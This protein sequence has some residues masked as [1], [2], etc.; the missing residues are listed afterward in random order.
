MEPRQARIPKGPDPPMSKDPQ[1]HP[2]V[3]PYPVWW[4]SQKGSAGPKT[5]ITRFRKIA[6][7][8]KNLHSKLGA[9]ISIKKI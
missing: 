8:E 3:P 1:N 7:F 9:A 4:P 2:K 5:K 6:F